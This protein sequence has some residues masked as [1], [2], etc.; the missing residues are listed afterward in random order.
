MPFSKILQSGDH[1]LI[2]K[3]GKAVPQLMEA[4][5]K[6]IFQ[7][8]LFHVSA[9]QAALSAAKQAFQPFSHQTKL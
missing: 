2:S 4:Y 7:D 6:M 9:S 3:A 5:G 8:G 1:G